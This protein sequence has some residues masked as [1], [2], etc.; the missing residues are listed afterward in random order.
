MEKHRY[1]QI[2]QYEM[3]HWWYVGRRLLLRNILQNIHLKKTDLVLDYGCGTG[4]TLTLLKTYASSEG[5]D[6]DRQALRYCTSRGHK[7]LH[8]ISDKK[9]PFRAS[10]FSLITCL[11]VLEHIQDDDAILQEFYRILKPGG[12]LILFVPAFP[13][14]WGDLDVHS[15]HKRRYTKNELRRKMEVNQF[16]VTQTFYFNFIFFIP[17]FLI[18]QLQRLRIIPMARNWGVYPV[19]GSKRINDFISHIFEYDI[20]IAPRLNP[21]FGVSIC[22][23][24]TK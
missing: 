9:L 23:I 3:T 7:K 5:A 10:H 18:R 1:D 15:H 13:S 19:V 24:A 4:A 20:R 21:P 2:F 12:T 22:T 14:L 11:D 6:I 16:A 8:K 17:I